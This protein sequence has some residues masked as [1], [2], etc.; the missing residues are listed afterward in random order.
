ME[1]RSTFHKEEK[2]LEIITQGIA[3][4]E[5]SLNMA[6]YIAET[7]R[8]NR[9][10]KVLI[11]H[12]SIAGIS[13]KSIEIYDRPKS[14]RLLGVLLGVK[15]AEII[16]PEHIEHFRFF[17]TVCINQGFRLSIFKEKIDALKWLLI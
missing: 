11:D 13:G 6:K 3:D 5:G 1:W 16:N 2:Y 7:M 8:S 4:N 17:E 9:I 14:F 15:I 12:R 10:T